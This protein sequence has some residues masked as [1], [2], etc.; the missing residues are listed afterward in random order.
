LRLYLCLLNDPF[1]EIP[2]G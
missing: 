2:Q 1:L